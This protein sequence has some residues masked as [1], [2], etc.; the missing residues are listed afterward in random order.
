[1]ENLGVNNKK[2]AI[3]YSY[4]KKNFY[5]TANEKT[6]KKVDSFADD[7]MRFLNQCKTERESFEFFKDQ[8]LNNGF[9]EFDFGDKLEK[10]GNYFYNV[11]GKGIVLFHVGDND[12][13]KDGIRIVASHIDS[14]RI[15][16]KQVPL[17]ES[18][19]LCFLKTHYY[20][21]IKKYQWTAIPLSLHGVVVLKN[22]EK[23]EI[24]LG[25]KDDEPV[26]YINDLLPHLG[27]NQMEQ[28]AKSVI[29]GE[30]LNIV[31]GAKPLKTD[32][33]D[34]IKRMVLKILNEKYGMTEEDFLSSELSC[35]PAFKARNVGF[36]GS[37]IG[38]YGHDDR[39]CAYPAFQSIVDSAK[40]NHTIMCLLVDKEE[41]G[42]EGV[43]GMKSKVYEDIIEEICSAFNKNVRKVRATS[44]CISADVTAAFDANFP[45]VFEKTNAAILSCGTCMSKFT[46]SRG[47]SDSSD[48]SAE[49]VSKIRKIFADNNVV[50]QAA[51][52]GKVD[53]GGGGTVAKYIANLNIDTVDI[54]VPVISMHSPYELISKADLYST[55]QAF[56]AF[57]K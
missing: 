1:M 38:G 50:W 11:R 31:V 36:D 28:K 47:K 14:P 20:G 35:V 55:Y 30:Q 22:G 5:E 52:L 26:F 19:G 49:M 4:V 32:G 40:S 18:D 44:M 16:I 7:Y 3:D 42:S 41:I 13:E 2:E 25:E 46:G 33:N 6:L 57:Y 43:T 45:D 54:G 37:L 12:I 21:G 24:N 51:E 23:V 17:Y 9:K 34:K 48:A 8:A 39:V 27:Q 53:L 29:T 56:C 15:D 10:G